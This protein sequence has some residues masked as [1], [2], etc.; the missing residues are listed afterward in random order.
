MRISDWSSDVCSS[1]LF[2]HRPGEGGG[3]GQSGGKRA[4]AGDEMVSH[5]TGLTFRRKGSTIHRLR[6]GQGDG[7]RT[8]VPPFITWSIVSSTVLS[9]Y[10]SAL[11]A[12]MS[13]TGPGANAPR[14]A[15]PNPPG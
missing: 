14:C 5:E 11:T 6:K 13:A 9:V 15:R 3:G 10:G 4:C 2:G 12:T 7:Y 8:I 1:D